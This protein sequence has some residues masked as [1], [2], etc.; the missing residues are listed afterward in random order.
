MI[1]RHLVFLELEV[2]DSLLQR[3]L[4]DLMGQMVLFRK[5]RRRDGV[6]MGE[7]V[8]VKGVLK[9]VP[10][11]RV[12]IELIVV[13]VVAD[14]RGTLRMPLEIRLELLLK[15]GVLGGNPRSNRLR[16]LGG[17]TEGTYGQKA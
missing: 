10:G 14:R 9:L 5:P 3:P 7:K 8:F 2:R 16:C 6:Q 4:H 1:H 17:G 11:R 13:S 15:K 12:V